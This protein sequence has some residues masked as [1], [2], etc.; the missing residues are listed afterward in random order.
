MD[1]LTT[2]RAITLYV[3]ALLGP[4]VLLMPG[5]AV[6]LAGPASIVA[7]GGL[8]VLS[9]LLATMFAAL[10][11][12]LPGG[13]GAAG[14]AGAAFGARAERAVA[15]CFL[16]GA[17]LGAPVVCLIGASY[18]ARPFGGGP[19]VTT[20]LAAVLLVL[21]V[22]GTARGG[23]S[24]ARLQ[25]GLVGV[26]VALVTVA[27]VAALPHARAAHWTPFAPHGWAAVGS[28]GSVLMLAFVG[29][30]AVSPM[31]ARLRDPRR[32]LPRIVTTAFVVTALVYL[33]LA[34]TTVGVLGTG[35]TTAV[36]DLLRVGVGPAGSIAA[37]VIAVALTLAATNAYLGGAAAMATAVSG[38]ATARRLPAGVAGVG[39]VL[40]IGTGAGWWTTTTLVAL[41]T[42]LFLAV[43]LV[44]TAAGVR[45]LAGG[46][47]IAAA[48]SCVA[49]GVVVALAGVAAWAAVAVVALALTRG[50]RPDG[51]P[52]R[53]AA[54]M[55]HG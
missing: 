29:W 9:G 16:G 53:R 3:G 14:F 20:A 34:A 31:T 37:A 43:Y 15:V 18:A 47:R 35:S 39:L 55:A 40:L 48:A 33:A 52:A 41:P 6:E 8:L 25:L 36:A 38:P 11:R 21:V 44:A 19:G 5:L 23:R 17:V 12:R 49:V 28:A 42:A 51:R 46:M 45:L 50:V 13:G 2:P 4:S 7:W 22:A 1:E 24:S 54:A 32:Q 30:E 10:G 27:V 26:L